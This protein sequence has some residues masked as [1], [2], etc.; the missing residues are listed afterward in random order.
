MPE[1]LDVGEYVARVFKPLVLMK[2]RHCGEPGHK[3]SSPSCMALAPKA[4]AGTM[5]TVRGG[6]NPLSNV[7][8]CPEGC[9]L[10]DGQHDFPSAEH[11]Y[12]FK[13]LRFHGK[14]DDSYHILEVESGFQ[15]MKIAHESLLQEES[16]EEWKAIAIHEMMDTNLLKYRSCS[17]AKASLLDSK[18]IVAEATSD[19]FWGSG[20]NPEMTRTTL[21]DYWPG[22]NN[23]GKILMQIHEDFLDDALQSR[24]DDIPG[25]P[26]NKRKAI[27]PLEGHSKTFKQ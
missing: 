1:M 14:L 23:L 19:K 3:A 5:E 26:G 9:L 21:S 8:T 7:H 24:K 2:C 6:I 12:Q 27:S 4:I 17:H 25:T 20:M 13:R 11:H 10:P 22:K 15:A 18:V 16:S